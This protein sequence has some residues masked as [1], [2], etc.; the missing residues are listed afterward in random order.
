MFRRA[1][2]LHLSHGSIRDDSR[3]CKVS[4]ATAEGLVGEVCVMG[5]RSRE[6]EAAS[7]GHEPKEI[8][9]IKLWTGLF[10]GL[11]PRLAAYFGLVE[12]T[13]RMA[14]RG[15]CVRPSIVQCHD[16]VVLPAAWMVS[17]LVGSLVVYD[18]HE[19][20]SERNGMS[21]R[22]SRLCL[23]IERWCWRRISLLV[24]V[25]PPILD[26]YAANL[27]PKRS[28]LVLNSPVLPSPSPGD[29]AGARRSFGQQGYFHR[30][31][32]IPVGTPV[33]IY[34]GYRMPGRGIE[35]VLRAFCRDGVRAHVVFVGS[36]DAV[37][38][39]EHAARCEK[40][41]LHP[42]V[43]HDQV[44]QLVREADCGLCLI[45]D[46]SLSDR[47]CLPNKL[48]EYAFAG[49]PVLA[50]R[51]PEIAR[52]VG[53]YGLGI[54]CDNDTDSIEAAV[55]K[56]ERDG[57]EPPTGDLTELSWET[58]AKRLQ[59]AYRTLLAERKLGTADMTGER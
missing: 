36:G 3:V 46:V 18:A 48:F 39:R 17:M 12:M 34:L 7:G 41:H 52:V 20:E 8:D 5:V 11:A 21:Q 43:P 27:G 37:G 29:A 35:S 23:F 51:L 33:F 38:V 30:R 49:V 47:L 2:V 54:C 28:V 40:I 6:D 32:N 26:W 58:Q 50:S 44:V 45:E 59:E 1:T 16:Y 10:R 31:F 56:I 55:R 19:L 15:I 4:V 57:I 24:S 13:V 14:L 9:E 53:E 25:S 42:A 22:A